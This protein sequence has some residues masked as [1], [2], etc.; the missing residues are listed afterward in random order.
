MMVENVVPHG[1][2]VELE[3]REGDGYSPRIPSGMGTSP[4]TSGLPVRSCHFGVNSISS[5]HKPGDLDFNLG[6]LY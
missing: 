3:Q 4:V 2:H 1:S 5:Y 6:T